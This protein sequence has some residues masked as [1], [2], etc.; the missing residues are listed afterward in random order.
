MVNSCKYC[1][2]LDFVRTNASCYPR[3]LISYWYTSTRKGMNLMV[4]ISLQGN[5]KRGMEKLE[6]KEK[7]NYSKKITNTVS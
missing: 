6:I 7:D 3:P 5:V 2:G 1:L 4:L